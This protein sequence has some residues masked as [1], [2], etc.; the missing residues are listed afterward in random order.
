MLTEESMSY[1]DF[2]DD[3]WRPGAV[4]DHGPTIMWVM[5]LM[6]SLFQNPVAMSLVVDILLPV[7]LEAL[8]LFLLSERVSR[9]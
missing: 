3:P 1:L 7:W 5:F 8:L 9:G 2:M 4:K 6:F